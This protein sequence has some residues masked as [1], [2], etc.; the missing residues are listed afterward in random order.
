MEPTTKADLHVH[1]K[2]SKRPSQWVLQKIGCAESYTEPLHLYRTLRDKGM[3]LITIT[4]HNTIEGSLDIAHLPDTFVSEEITAYFP[5]DRCKVHVLAYDIT[6]AQHREIQKYRD[7]VFDLAEYLRRAE[8]LHVLAHPLFS[9][10]DKLTKA[11]FEQLLLLFKHFEINGARDEHLNINLKRILGGLSPED[12]QRLENVH[13]RAALPPEPWI[14]HLTG[15]SDDHSS[16]NMARTHTV[17]PGRRDVTGFLNGVR[18]GEAIPVGVSSSPQTLAHNLYSIAYQFYAQKFE[19]RK[20]VNKDILLKFIDRNLYPGR[21][22]ESGLLGSLHA[23]WSQRIRPR[24]GPGSRRN[25]PEQLQDLLRYETARLIWNDPELMSIVRSSDNGREGQGKAWF[26]FVNRS[27]NQ[28]MKHSADHMLRKIAQGSIFNIFH[29]L[30]SA[31]ALYTLLA[32]YFLSYSMFAHDRK[33]SREIREALAADKRMPEEQQGEGQETRD[34]ARNDTRNGSREHL[35]ARVAH[36]TDTYYEV[37]GVALTLQQQLS[38]AQA[39]S[40]DMTIITCAPDEAVRA[41]DGVQNFTPIG[42]F[43]LPEYPELKLF[44]PPVLE[45]MRFCFDKEITHIHSATPGPIGLAALALA[46]LMHL[47]IYGTYHTSLPQYT[48]CLTQD[49]AME[50][51]MWRFT[52][53]YYDQMDLVFAPSHATANELI[54][55]GLRPEKVRVYPRGIDIERFHPSKRNGFYEKRFQLRNEAKLLYVGRVSKEKNLHILEQAFRDLAR[56]RN[57]VRLIIVGD[58]PYREEMERNLG[59]TPAVFTGYLD[60]EALAQAYAS[61]DVFVF[62]STTDTFG[63]VVLE[64][65][66]SG[67]PVIVSAEGG[68]QENLIPGQTGFIVPSTTAEAYRQAMTTL[69]DN[70]DLLRKMRTQARNY[71]ENRS[72]SRS[73]DQVWAYYGQTG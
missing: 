66:A 19:L 68:P 21:E 11:H 54:A 55:K 37:N 16:L 47:P 28:V 30:G 27:A 72:F 26:S 24:I 70:P 7:N 29:S 51:L 59:G 49:F 40:K 6:E 73:F 61:A 12:I 23:L 65:Q 10:N 13:D 25:P 56:E 63:N 46:K 5:E 58:G 34:G 45:M 50:E 38:L 8:I 20:H 17:V 35:A 18:N 3:D 2:Y 43:E 57:D 14:K 32:P 22:E 31:G 69:L 39:T 53:W 4:D 48:K 60:G 44:Y 67:L 9:V 42:V 71:M 52:L 1:S 33:F 41:A 62:P 36:F 64:A 15:G